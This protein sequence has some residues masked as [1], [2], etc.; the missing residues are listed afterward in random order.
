[1]VPTADLD[2]FLEGRSGE[3][4]AAR[5]REMAPALSY[6][7]HR[8][9]ARV[10][11]RPAAVAIAMYREPDGQWMIPLTLRPPTLRH[12][13]GQVC[14]PGGRVEPGEGVLEAAVR[15][16]EEELGIRADLTS[17]HR[18]LSPQYVYASDHL[19]HPVAFMIRPPPAPWRPDPA[20]VADVIVMPL[21]ILSDRSRR[22]GVTVTRTLH[23][24]GAAVGKLRFRAAAWRF[25]GHEIWGATALI[26]DELAQVLHL[27]G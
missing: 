11:S 18:E 27:T 21:D 8:G 16:F 14:L 1:M 13:G 10:G 9:P 17:P 12:H 26:L 2:R 25:H 7:R 15:E 22:V 20:E 6:G 3:A 5:L 24:Q 4:S 19:V 23:R